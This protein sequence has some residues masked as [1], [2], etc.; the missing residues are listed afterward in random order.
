MIPLVPHPAE[1]VC[2]LKHMNICV[3]MCEHTHTHTHSYIH[4]E[5]KMQAVFID[6]IASEATSWPVLSSEI[7]V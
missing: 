3:L 2:T 1:H 6:S 7:S 5:E 4:T